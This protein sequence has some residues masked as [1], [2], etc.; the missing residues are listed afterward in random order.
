MAANNA[1]RA[2]RLECLSL[3]ECMHDPEERAERLRFARMWIS[4]AN[5]IDEARGSYEFPREA[6]KSSNLT[7]NFLQNGLQKIYGDVQ[8]EPVPSQLT[9]LLHRLEGR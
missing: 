7:Y 5:Q 6:E 3:A 1:Y 4:L 8:S 2:K 9:S